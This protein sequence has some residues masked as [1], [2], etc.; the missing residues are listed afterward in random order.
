MLLYYIGEFINEIEK[1]KYLVSLHFTA[2]ETRTL[3]DSHKVNYHLRE[4]SGVIYRD[5]LYNG[6]VNESKAIGR[7]KEDGSFEIDGSPYD[8]PYEE[9]ILGA[10]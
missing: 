7:K 6:E 8:F 2:H 9:Y 4:D 1:T 3:G 10:P 5:N